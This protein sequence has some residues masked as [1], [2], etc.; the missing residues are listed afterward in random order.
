MK[1]I[2]Q[3]E[4]WCVT[5]GKCMPI[6]WPKYGWAGGNE[7]TLQLV[8]DG[9][10]LTPASPN[11]LQARDAILLADKIDNAGANLRSR[12]GKALPSGAWASAPAPRMGQR[13]PA[14]LRLSTCRACLWPR[15]G[16]RAA[17]AMALWTI[18]NAMTCR[19]SWGTTPAPW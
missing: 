1:S 10:K 6:W 18:M 7:L 16:S 5:F 14:W 13:P 19:S 9:M 11:F 8:T 17:T 3:G 15:W 12:S 4:V 2:M